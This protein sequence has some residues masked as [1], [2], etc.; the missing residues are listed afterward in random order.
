MKRNT[1]VLSFTNLKGG[2]TKTTTSANVGACLAS[3]GYKVLM[4]DWDPQ[5]NLTMHFNYDPD[6]ITPLFQAL[7]I[8][9]EKFFNPQMIK[10]LPVE[11]YPDR[12]FLLGNNFDLCLFEG[13]FSNPTLTPNPHKVLSDILQGFD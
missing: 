11:Y 9:A 6:N 2:G 12:L 13:Q 5:A 8:R 7:D 10:V 3:M 1:K 4:V